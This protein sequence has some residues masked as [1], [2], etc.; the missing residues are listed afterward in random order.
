M[1]TNKDCGYWLYDDMRNVDP[2]EQQRRAKTKQASNDQISKSA[3]TPSF[4]RERI[5]I[6]T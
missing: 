2:T 1:A 5:Q 3:D 4:F 6:S